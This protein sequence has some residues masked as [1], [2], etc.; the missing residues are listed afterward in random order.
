MIYTKMSQNILSSIRSW[1]LMCLTAALFFLSLMPSQAITLDE[2]LLADIIPDEG[3]AQCADP[4]TTSTTFTF[5][6]TNSNSEWWSGFLS[7]ES[8]LFLAEMHHED[9]VHGGRRTWTIRIGEGGNIYS[10]YAPNLFGEAIPP[11]A[12]WEAPWIDEVLQTVSVDRARNYKAAY[13][14]KAYYIHQA[15]AYQRDGSYTSTPFYSPNVAKHCSGNTCTFA[16]WGQQAHVPTP[17]TSPILYIHRYRNCGE[18]VIEYTQTIHNFADPATTTPEQAV[19]DYFNTAWGGVRVSSLPYPLEPGLDRSLSYADPSSVDHAPACRW[20]SSGE[21]G[22]IRQLK[23]LGGYTTFAGPGLK[24]GNRPTP[25]INIPCRKPLA[26]G[27]DCWANQGTCMVDSCTDAQVANEGY[28]RLIFKVPSGGVNCN[29]HDMYN[30]KVCLQCNIIEQGFGRNYNGMWPCD[31]D[32]IM[33]KNPATNETLKVLHIRHW[34]WNANNNLVSSSIDSRQY[35]SH[36]QCIFW[37]AFTYMH[38]YI[39]F[40]YFIYPLTFIILRCFCRHTFPLIIPTRAPALTPPGPRLQRN[41]PL[42]RPSRSFR[43]L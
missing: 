14:N 32:G 29:R 8:G 34:S 5:P 23:Q 18:G 36:V 26:S 38:L 39:Q 25:T 43:T 7:Y 22:N 2:A 19:N 37:A 41:S 28:T 24:V 1:R 16:S 31:S 4:G 17:F 13:G 40:I 9:T 42:A 15:G 35:N 3:S 33:F 27:G 10:H 12:H 11:Q 20:G 6:G 30:G 21:T